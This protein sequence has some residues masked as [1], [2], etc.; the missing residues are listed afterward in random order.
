[1]YSRVLLDLML[2]CHHDS[3]LKK[4]NHSEHRSFMVL[5]TEESQF[6]KTKHQLHEFYSDVQRMM[7][8]PDCYIMC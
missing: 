2:Y 1:M 8:N 7:T 5:S 6:W 4:V 3:K